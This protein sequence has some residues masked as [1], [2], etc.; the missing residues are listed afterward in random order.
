[1][2]ESIPS[3]VLLASLGFVL[4]SQPWQP[5]LKLQLYIYVAANFDDKFLRSIFLCLELTFSIRIFLGW[6]DRSF[7][8]L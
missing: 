6:S 3:K 1:M 7:K 8:H 5:L 2:T 4:Y